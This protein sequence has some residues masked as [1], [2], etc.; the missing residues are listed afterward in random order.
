MLAGLADTALRRVKGRRRA[1]VD[2][3]IDFDLAFRLGL[4]VRSRAAPDVA[5][6]D[7]IA[8]CCLEG[9][10][11]GC[12][13]E[14]RVGNGAARRLQEDVAGS[15]Y[16]RIAQVPGLDVAGQDDVTASGRFDSRAERRF[17]GAGEADIAIFRRDGGHIACTQARSL[18]GCAGHNGAVIRVDVQEV[19]CRDVAV[20]DDVPCCSEVVAVRG[21]DDGVACRTGEVACKADA[22]F[23]GGEVCRLG[24]CNI[25]GY[26]D[27]PCF[28]SVASLIGC[29][30]SIAEAGDD[31][32]AG[33]RRREADVTAIGENGDVLRRPF[34]E[35]RACFRR[36][37]L[38]AAVDADVAATGLDRRAENGL[39]QALEVNIAVI[40]ADSNSVRCGDD[41]ARNRDV[42]FQ[43]V[44]TSCVYV[45][46]GGTDTG[47]TAVSRK[48]ACEADIAF[49]GCQAGGL[50][51]GN[52]TG[53]GNAAAGRGPDRSVVAAA[54]DRHGIIGGREGNSAVCSL[55]E[56]I[57]CLTRT[58]Q[59]AFEP[60]VAQGVSL[61]GRAR[62]R[63]GTA[64]E[65]NIPFILRR[66]ACRFQGNRSACGR[67]GAGRLGC[68]DG[69]IAALGL[70]EDALAGAEGTAVDDIASLADELGCAA[71][72]TCEV[73]GSG[74]G[75]AR[76]VNVDAVF[77]QCACLLQCEQDGVRLA[78]CWRRCIA[79]NRTIDGDVTAGRVDVDGLAGFAVARE[80]DV[81][82]SRDD[83]DI[84]LA[85]RVEVA[86]DGKVTA[87]DGLDSPNA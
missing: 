70:E 59:A 77:R 67:E 18:F 16:R 49:C 78:L 55:D 71:C 43:I 39:R 13:D 80:L 34:C 84:A 25:T 69:D 36:D 32:C 11:T 20:D 12:R 74:D 44:S 41:I 14:A 37:G 75:A 23:A 65:G 30:V 86:R 22:A 56:D 64:V 48:I 79:R 85:C 45:F 31:R 47:C 66:V 52:V 7:D 53:Y 6:L 4:D 17:D 35:G 87:R 60:D 58:L 62:Y 10:S 72:A 63:G 33:N 46:I 42:A 3:A 57:A 40:R 76:A 21:V 29:D 68:A 19:L 83:V 73:A 26:A 61:D 38:E 28:L 24:G 8:A 51:G 27:V 54:D 5:S 2:V 81:A 1:A 9:S 15:F 50:G 82:R